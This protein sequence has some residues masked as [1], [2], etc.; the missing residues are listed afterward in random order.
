MKG[1]IFTLIFVL[2]SGL[3][4]GQAALQA[5]ETYVF[6]RMW[7]E[8]QQPWYFNE[9]YDVAVDKE[10]NVFVADTFNHRIQKFSPDGAF[11]TA[12]GSLG[13]GDGQ[14]KYPGGIATDAAGNIFVVDTGNNRIQKL[15]SNGAFVTAW[16]SLGSGDGQFNSPWGIATDAAGNILVADAGNHRIQKFGPDGAFVTAWGSYGSGDG[17]FHFPN[18]IA[19]D[20]AGNVFVAD[21]YNDRIQKFGP[22]GEFVTAWGSMG[23]GDG[24][25]HFPEGIATDAEGSLFVADNDRIQK[26]GP[27]K[28]F[29]TAWGSGSSGDG[30]FD[31][32]EGIAIDVAGNIFVADTDNHR[33]QKFDP[34]GTFIKAWGSIG[35]GDVR[36]FF[37]EG[38]ATDATGNIFVADSANHR[39]QKFGPDG[40]F[41]TAWGSEGDGD[42]QFNSCT[43]IDID[44]TGNIFVVDMYND[45]IQKFGPDGVFVTAWGSEGDG[46]GQFDNP[47]IITADAFGYVFVAD[48]WND[49]IQKFG[50]D[51]TFVTAWG[52]EGDGD[53]QFGSP[54]GIATDAAGNIF[55]ADSGNH[56][57]QI[58]TSDGEFIAKFGIFGSEP[59]L[60]NRPS[61]LCVGP[62]GRVYV[63]DSANN[64]IQ[65][66]RKNE[67]TERIPKA[68]IVAGSGPGDWNNLWDATQMCATFAYRA[69]LYQGF[70]K[71]SI[72]YL[73]HDTDLDFDGNGIPDVDAAATND[74]LRTAI[75]DW[76]KDA[77]DLFIYM[78][79]HGGEGTF[80]MGGIELLQAIDLDNW[81]DTVQEIIPGKVILVYDVCRSGSFLPLLT[82]PSGKRRILAASASASQEAIF[83]THGR[84][85]FSF[86]FWAGMFN[87]NSFYDSFKYAKKAVALTYLQASQLDAD[88]DG[89][90]NEEADQEIAR[91]VVIGNETKS[92]GDIPLI[93]GISPTQTLTGE[94]SAMIYA[95]NVIDADGISRVW[96]VIMPPGYS[97]GSPDIP[98][99]TLP[100]VDLKSVG[101]DRYEAAYTGFHA[102]GVYNIA[103]FANDRG[104]SISMPVQTYIIR[105]DGTKLK[106]D[107][108]GDAA[109]NLKD[110]M[111]AL[112]VAA[113]VDGPIPVRSDYISSEIDLSG[114]DRIGVEEVIYI[115][116]DVAGLR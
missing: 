54:T 62:D 89:I 63:A 1:K 116:Q 113:G 6:E 5:E 91:A 83:A 115:L 73:S 16:G 68:I 38:I 110:A 46:D 24:Q 8:L 88:G 105:T 25:F 79:G 55:V 60:L 11:V 81:L 67:P 100:T 21:T 109:M 96:A 7:P 32:P 98:A 64:R 37:P 23:S 56:R 111:I 82:P 13:S 97:S 94:T 51:G 78:V 40:A 15:G 102:T 43:G 90:G 103:I 4:A 85:S 77:E 114:D 66:F 2:I 48:T 71:E 65:V 104:S 9:P 86:I 33:I 93:T 74:N 45:R 50:P 31:D 28:A 107:I 30:R 70:T 53:G 41:V 57:I 76:A 49:R 92:A 108:N 95:E 75:T 17:Q 18:R 34:D 52:S 29:V 44:A 12:W 99:T 101:N 61:D 106:G 47:Q 112:K 27:D 26:F 80:R 3:F 72:Y 69:L 14:F 36:F 10:G 35:H 59:G 19:T 20:S 42:G 84:V 87:G 39:I 58:F 22:D